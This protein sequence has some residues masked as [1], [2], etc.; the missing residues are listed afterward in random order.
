[1]ATLTRDLTPEELTDIQKYF[2]GVKKG[3][4]AVFYAFGMKY[5]EP[6][7]RAGHKSASTNPPEMPEEGTL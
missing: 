1:M 7:T 4:Y 2:S 5:L 6:K 3:D